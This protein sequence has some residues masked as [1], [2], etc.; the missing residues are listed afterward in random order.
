VFDV[1]LKNAS[2]KAIIELLPQTQALTSEHI[3]SHLQKFR[4]HR[5]RSREE[6]LSHYEQSV[7]SGRI[8]LGNLTSG[9]CVTSNNPGGNIL[10]K[11]TRPDD[12]SLALNVL[13]KQFDLITSTITVQAAFLD[14]LRGSISD[15]KRVKQ[16]LARRLVQLDP[17]LTQ[18]STVAAELQDTNHTS[19]PNDNLR[20]ENNPLLSIPTN[21]VGS[22]VAANNTALLMASEMQNLKQVHHVLNQRKESQMALFSNNHSHQTHPQSNHPNNQNHSNVIN[23]NTR[24]PEGNLNHSKQLSLSSSNNNTNT[25][26]SPNTWSSSQTNTIYLHSSTDQSNPSY[27]SNSTS[28]RTKAHS[29]SHTMGSRSYSTAAGAATVHGEQ[30]NGD[31]ITSSHTTIIYTHNPH[32]HEITAPGVD[33]DGVD[34]D[35]VDLFDFLWEGNNPHDGEGL[36]MF[37]DYPGTSTSTSPSDIMS[38]EKNIMMKNEKQ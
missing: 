5:G 2:P 35:D 38:H 23:S 4:V 22:A 25:A 9:M 6:F 36:S 29:H 10:P 17:S 7:R 32:H 21:L 37:N 15:Q 1:G 20:I 16:D 27:E 24:F 14:T 34:T 26:N 28:S 19:T 31:H 18:N 11:A 8:P 13:R 33:S 3:K 30:G 12:K